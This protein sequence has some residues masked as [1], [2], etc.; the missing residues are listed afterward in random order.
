MERTD[1]LIKVIAVVV[2]IALMCYV[3]YYFIDSQLNPLVTASAMEYT[4]KDTASTEG[5]A[6]R[7]EE[8]LSEG[9]ARVS[10][11]A[12]ECEKLS[13]GS[14]YAYKFRTRQAME[15]ADR[16]RELELRIAWLEALEANGTTAADSMA[17]DSVRAVAYSTKGGN[18]SDIQENL[19]DIN[20]T[21]FQNGEYTE[22]KI[23]AELESARAEL[24]AME[25]D[26]D[27]DMERLTVSV[28][29][30]YSAYTDGF[31]SV[32]AEQL[33]GL[34]PT[35]L[36]NLF[37][38][39]GSNDSR[40]SGKLVTGIDWRYAAIIDTENA[41]KLEEGRY[42]DLE[43]SN[44]YNGTVNMRVE[45]IGNAAGGRCVV[46]FVSDRDLTETI[47]ARELTADIVFSLTT[48][49]R[50]P[51][52]AMHR[53]EETGQTYVYVIS[54]VQALRVDASVVG[55]YDDYYLVEATGNLRDGMEVIVEAKDL[56]N[57]KVVR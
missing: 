9:S 13:A 26:Q 45:S 48:G 30:I 28:P 55:E 5:Y 56:Y 12:E 16:T 38:E 24:E 37:K 39:A 15:A 52:A 10:V 32:T 6:V 47:A 23:Q 18:F 57:G 8:Q 34:S 1:T 2:F 7:T 41:A 42:Y 46:V 36:E 40:V 11:T 29:G 4:I 33:Q 17:K 49:I 27:T 50:I 44:T 20:V 22:D 43:F 19:A 31:E 51:T 3:G 21:V 54:G 14:T 35:E 53:D 25:N